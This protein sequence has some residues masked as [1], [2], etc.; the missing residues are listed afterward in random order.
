MKTITHQITLNARPEF[1]YEMLTD[2]STHAD[3]LGAGV[4]LDPTEGGEFTTFDEWA[5]GKNLELTP[6]TRI[7]QSWRAHTE[8]WPEDHFSTVEFKLTEQG[9]NTTLLEFTQHNVPDAAY[10]EI[11]KGWHTY[12]WEPMAAYIA[13]HPPRA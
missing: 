9:D 8:G 11:D 10:D 7:K 13:D 12:Y 3:M 6:N 1:I 5:D 2:E 4:T